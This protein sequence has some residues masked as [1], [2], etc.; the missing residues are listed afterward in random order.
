MSGLDPPPQDENGLDIARTLRTVRQ[1]VRDIDR[2]EVLDEVRIGIFSFAK[3]LMWR[4]LKE[5][6]ADLLRS[7]VVAQLVERPAAVRRGRLV[8]A[9]RTARR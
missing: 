5:R 6:A 8:S 4:D 7:P 2:W 9:A 3:F 1:A